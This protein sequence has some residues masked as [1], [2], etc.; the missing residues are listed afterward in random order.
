MCKVSETNIHWCWRY[1]SGRTQF[2]NILSIWANNNGNKSAIVN[3]ILTLLHRIHG[4]IVVHACIKC[5]KQILIGFGDI[6]PE[7]QIFQIFGQFWANNNGNKS[8]ILNLI[9]MKLHRIHGSIAVNDCAK[10]WKKILIGV[11]DMHPDRQNFQILCQFEQTK[12]R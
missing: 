11:G 10:Y 3:L 8:T 7:G 4:R 1:S 5:W 12:W 9:Q 6:H 2:S